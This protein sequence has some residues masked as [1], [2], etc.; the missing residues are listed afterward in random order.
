MRFLNFFFFKQSPHHNQLE[1]FLPLYLTA[2]Y[3]ISFPS[4]TS[5]KIFSSKKHFMKI[6]CFCLQNRS[7]YWILFFSQT[8]KPQGYWFWYFFELT[9][10][11]F[12]VNCIWS[13]LHII[14]SVS[15]CSSN[16]SATI[17]LLSLPVHHYLF[18]S[19]YPTIVK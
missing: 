13:F 14:F 11:L 4:T 18:Y 16:S 17:P 7:S 2:K 15:V 9:F 10:F 1:I 19:H 12:F 8:C 5:S 3:H 6:Q